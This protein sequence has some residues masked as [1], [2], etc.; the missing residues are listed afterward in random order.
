MERIGTLARKTRT[1]VFDEGHFR[2]F[3][4]Y[5][6]ESE[7]CT[8]PAP[9]AF[10][11]H[12]SPGWVLPTHYHLEDQFQVVTGGGGTL[13]NHAVGPITLH[14]SSR[15]AGYGP[16][17]AGPHGVDYLTLRAV[18]DPGAWYLPESRDK[19]RRGLRKRQATAGPTLVERPEALAALR[20][21]TAEALIAPEADGLAAWIVRL[22]PDGHCG[23]P[24]HAGSGG[25]YHV[26][27]SGALL[28]G[29]ESLPPPACVWR[30]AEDPPM[31]M[32]A[33]PQGLEILVLQYPAAAL[34]AQP[35]R[36]KAVGA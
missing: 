19:M 4:E 6:I 21:A 16:L 18:T 11:V 23:A 30:A 5:L 29:G 35:E 15:E 26:V 22:P 25:R 27:V 33:G 24:E 1:R 20:A 3:T 28:V 14:Y 13:G 17:I 32:Q 9:Q 34:H 31:E 8:R 36:M 12:Q 10:L 7:P 2:G